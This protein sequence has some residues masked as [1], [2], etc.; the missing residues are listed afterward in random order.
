MCVCV[1]VCVCA[2]VQLTVSTLGGGAATAGFLH[3]MMSFSVSDRARLSALVNTEILSE[4]L[5]NP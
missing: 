4:F 2:H 5:A 1:C 3:R